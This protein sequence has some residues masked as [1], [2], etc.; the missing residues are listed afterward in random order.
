MMLVN[1]RAQSI[2]STLNGPSGLLIGE[3]NSNHPEYPPKRTNSVSLIKR[4]DQRNQPS[5]V[6]NNRPSTNKVIEP[7]IILLTQDQRQ[8]VIVDE[9]CV[10]TAEELIAEEEENFIKRL[11]RELVRMANEGVAFTLPAVAVDQQQVVTGKNQQQ[12]LLFDEGIDFNPEMDRRVVINDCFYDEGT[13][14]F[15][16]LGPKPHIINYS[17]AVGV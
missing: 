8:S 9:E 12:S 17:E 6:S 10:P 5:N 15:N 7:S 16:R 4:H 2:L 11:E 3:R 1:Q 13:S 14:V